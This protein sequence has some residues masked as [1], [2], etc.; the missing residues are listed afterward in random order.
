MAVDPWLALGGLLVL[1]LLAEMALLS[2]LETA[3]LNARRSR[4]AG[5]GPEGRLRAAES[6]LEQP[7]PFQ[8]SA[9]LA[10]SLS[11]AVLYASAAFLGL[12]LR[13]V[14]RGGT[15]P[16]TL[17]DL[18]SEAWPAILIA[19]LLA[20][21]AVTLLGE[22]LPKALAARNPE[23]VLVRGSGFIQGFTL[24]LTP[25]RLIAGTLGRALARSTGAIPRLTARAAH[26][27]EEIKLLV[28]GSTEE[29]VFEHEEKEMIHSVIEFSDTIARQVMVPRIDICSVPHDATVE[30]VVT[31]AMES[32]HSRLPV[33]EGTLDTIVGVVHV[34]DLL[35]LLL[36]GERN[37]PISGVLRQPYF[38]PE[39]KKL[40]E[41]LQEFRR[42]KSQLAIVVD[43]FGGTAGLVTVEDVL[44]EIVGE[45]Q[46]EYDVAEHPPLPEPNKG[47]GD[48]VVDARA[49]LS[50][51]NETYSLSLPEGE[52]DTLGGL[53]F[54]LLGRPA[55]LG[56][57]VS[58]AGTDLIVE[59]MDGL[60]LLKIRIVHPG[61]SATDGNGQPGPPPSQ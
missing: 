57:R 42:H 10:K 55:Q 27:E 48:I 24:A 6:V 26:S 18:L 14:A 11:E 44:E 22:A 17:G 52:N 31:A 56:E 35:P 38:V 3:V 39:G 28:E 53:V 40:D 51:V 19:A 50:D 37:G 36:A 32:G 54:S 25:V 9:H 43:E 46:D 59:A 7:E 60:R 49:L 47:G 2:T 58:V 15:V 21:L 23:R 61:E 8:T 20:F 12:E 4:L 33:Y 5:C 13:L 41:L 16:T 34:K 45:I 30:S 29:G 1:L